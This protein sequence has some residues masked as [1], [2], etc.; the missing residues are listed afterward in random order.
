MSYKCEYESSKLP[1]FIN[2]NTD[3][4]SQVGLDGITVADRLD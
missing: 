1:F 2:I 3:P 4:K